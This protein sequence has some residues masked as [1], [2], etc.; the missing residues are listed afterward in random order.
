MRIYHRKPPQETS[1]LTSWLGRAMLLSL[2]LAF[3]LQPLVATAAG[4]AGSYRTLGFMPGSLRQSF[5][6]VV[7]SDSHI[8]HA[9]AAKSTRAALDD[10]TA[11]YQDIS[12]MIH[13]GDV[14]ETGAEAQYQE[15]ESL[16]ATLPYP[17]I[18]TLGNHEARWQ[19]PQGSLFRSHMGS[20]NTSF[21]YGAWHFVVLDTTYPGETLGTLDPA[22]AKWLE[23]DLSRN[24]GRPVAIF[25][26]HPLLYLEAKFQDSDGAFARIMDKY[27]IRAVFSGHGHSFINWQAQ[28]QRFQMVGALMDGSYAQVSVNG[29]P[30][31]VKSVVP[32]EDGAY[33][34][35][36]IWQAQVAPASRPFSV[37]P[38]TG[39]AA[40]VED[41]VLT[42]SM[43]LSRSAALY[44]QID[45]GSFVE[46]GRRASGAQEFTLDVSKHA[47][48]R[49]SLTLKAVTAEGPFFASESFGKDWEDLAVWETDLGSAVVGPLLP[50]GSGQVIVGTSDG[51]VRN[52]DTTDG[53]VLWTFS[54]LSQ[55]GGGVLDGNR[56]YFGTADGVLHC[57]NAEEG[58]L[59]WNTS[60]DARGI[61]CPPAIAITPAG[62]VLVAP[63]TGGRVYGLNA[64]YGGRM[65]QFDAKG[66]VVSQPA[67]AGDKV[68]FGSWDTNIY[69]LE[70][71]SGSLSWSK[72]L[73][74]QVYYAPYLSP[75][76]GGNAVYATTPYDAS[77]GASYLYALD[78]ATGQEKWKVAGKTSLL[79]AVSSLGGYVTVMDGY[80][81]VRAFS[82]TDGSP[83]WSKPGGRAD[84]TVGDGH[85]FVTPLPLAVTGTS[86]DPGVLVADTRGSLFRISI[87]R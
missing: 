70:A 2:V 14:T 55:W 77:T 35:S 22:K 44:F 69:A 85:L 31:A 63:T 15:A 3:T 61:S 9:P 13:M 81:T 46:L 50:K 11:R 16:W 30:M 47:K 72:Q 75:S 43:D 21:N 23:D 26:H 54:A 80:G 74:R 8:G 58:S 51:F 6:F 67:V 71:S 38:V 56:L 34:E 39:L 10:I 79:G 82:Q 37:N 83:Q 73:G 25:T 7:A 87:P 84:F 60:L 41:G 48:G 52:I 78:M 42:A 65:W 1:T 28:G 62:K 4:L 76:V 53:K 24:P 19:D 66:A 40:S 86:A 68:Y 64:F 59:L 20:P 45:N 57:L 18:A 32:G 27:P 29:E 5:S 36:I 33:K 49:H 17:V 12:F